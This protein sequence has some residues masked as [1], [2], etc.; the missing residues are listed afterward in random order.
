ML[1]HLSS[2]IPS[3]PILFCP[4]VSCPVQSMKCVCVFVCVRVCVILQTIT[5]DVQLDT[6]NHFACYSFSLLTRV[7]VDIQCISNDI[8]PHTHNPSILCVCVHVYIHRGMCACHA[9][10]DMD[11]ASASTPSIPSPL[12]ARRNPTLTSKTLNHLTL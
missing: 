1:L 11:R 4:V 8:S 9:G 5:N 7:L 3:H 2:S 10:G 6:I 12:P